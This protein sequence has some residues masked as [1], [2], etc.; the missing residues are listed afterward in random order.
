MEKLH[1]EQRAMKKRWQ[2]TK[3]ERVWN[4]QHSMKTYFIQGASTGLIKIGKTAGSVKKRCDDLQV[5]SPDNLRVLKS[6]KRDIERGLHKSFAY[7]RT[8]GEWFRPAP[9]LLRFISKL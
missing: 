1:E 8:H 6:V 3:T 5:G 2:L 7:L 9:E 4:A